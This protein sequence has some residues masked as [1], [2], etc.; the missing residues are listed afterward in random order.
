MS[1]KGK[2]RTT[3]ENAVDRGFK[4]PFSSDRTGESS[5]F[6]QSDSDF[7]TDDCPKF[8]TA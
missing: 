2:L 7:E 5:K 4:S 1:F 6:R 8:K 3:G